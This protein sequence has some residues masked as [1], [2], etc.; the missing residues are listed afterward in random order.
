MDEI[1][2]ELICSNKLGSDIGSNC[3][4]ASEIPWSVFGVFKNLFFTAF[5]IDAPKLNSFL[6][7]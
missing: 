6:A 7:L 3:S 1:N 2:A 5:T 4:I